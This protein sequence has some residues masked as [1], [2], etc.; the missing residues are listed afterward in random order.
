MPL[1]I[2]Q[3]GRISFHLGYLGRQLSFS[4]SLVQQGIQEQS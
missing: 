2:A 1:C 3:T 4:L